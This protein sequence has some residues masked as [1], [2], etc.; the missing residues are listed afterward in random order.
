LLTKK[1]IANGKYPT[2]YK[3]A[4]PLSIF[5]RDPTDPTNQNVSLYF[6]VSYY[7]ISFLFFYFKDVPGSKSFFPVCKIVKQVPIPLLIVSNYNLQSQQVHV[8]SLRHHHQQDHKVPL[9]QDSFLQDSFLQ[10][11]VLHRAQNIARC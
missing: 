8:Q 5:A 3:E 7:H 11:N 1:K 6:K 4:F 10:D 2:D 9:P